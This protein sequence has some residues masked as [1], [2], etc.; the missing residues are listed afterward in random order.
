MHRS[1]R[2]LLV[3]GY[4]LV[5]AGAALF[6]YFNLW[7]DT[8]TRVEVSPPAGSEYERSFTESVLDPSDDL[9]A[10]ARRGSRAGLGLLGAGGVLALPAL[11]SLALAKRR[12]G[13]RRAPPRT[14]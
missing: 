14:D 3:A 12:A 5:V 2:A 13:S 1:L 7:F 9:V 4:L 10:R 11:V 8:W 6:L